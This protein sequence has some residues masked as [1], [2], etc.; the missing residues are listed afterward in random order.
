MIKKKIC[1]LGAFAVGKT[2]L[3]EKYVKSI[4]SDKYHTTIGVKTDQKDITIDGKEVR[5]I[6]WDIN[7]ED[8]YQHVKPSY[9]MGVSGYLLVVDGTRKET[10]Q[11]AFD[12][13]QLVTKTVG[14]KDFIL[15][16][17]KSDL[18]DSWELTE[19]EESQLVDLGWKVVRTSA[20]SGEN[21]N[22]TFEDL[23]KSI[24]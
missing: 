19:R 14:E 16:I 3:V 20:K 5:L 10:L 13:Q 7:G 22:A 12:L 4:F 24:I 8:D 15:M 2:S 6:I 17:N 21:V 18:M 11:V 23:A 1:I 9:L